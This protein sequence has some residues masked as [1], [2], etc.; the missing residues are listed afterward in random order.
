MLRNTE[1]LTEESS[2]HT[3]S[4]TESVNGNESS[5][6]QESSDGAEK[7]SDE[8]GEL[9][10]GGRESMD[11]DG[12]SSVGDEASSDGEDESSDDANGNPITTAITLE[13][14]KY[15]TGLCVPTNFQ[16]DAAVAKFAQRIFSS[17]HK[18]LSDLAR[19]KTIR[20]IGATE[21]INI[22]G[23]QLYNFP[24]RLNQSHKMLLYA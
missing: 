12:E 9:S 19:L 14:T 7:S 16:N 8:V 5:S 11:G 17:L 6:T 10:D 18:D 3:D 23:P 1:M 15:L 20:D 4:E 24:T 13:L 21:N 22:I 2:S